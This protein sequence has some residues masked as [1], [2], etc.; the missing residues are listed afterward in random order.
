MPPPYG[1]RSL[2]LTCHDPSERQFSKLALL[3]H[4]VARAPGSHL[5]RWD[6][7]PLELSR[8]RVLERFLISGH[9]S[10]REAR[11]SA[12]GVPPLG[13]R[14]LRLP[15]R[16]RLY[17]LGCS[18]GGT[19]QLRAWAEG[20]G[21]PEARVAGCPG[22]TET[23]VS[24]C[25]ALHLLEAGPEAIERW[26]PV[27]VQCNEE[28]RPHFPEIRRAYREHGT[29]PVLTL[30][31]LSARLDLGPFREFLSVIDRH[32]EYLRGLMGR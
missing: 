18:Q 12:P 32:P 30:R 19:S 21:I 8:R 22:E 7:G 14:D 23:A 9:G 27:W 28:L 6:G 11:F 4:R 26:F 13:P 5:A 20:T 17:L 31:A 15:S 1:L 29:D 2:F 3:L 10:D 25:L 24:T 16:C